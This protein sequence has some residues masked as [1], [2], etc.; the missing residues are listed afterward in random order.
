MC[1]EFD[2]PN[3]VRRYN[4]PCFI[5]EDCETLK[6]SQSVTVLISFVSITE[7]LGQCIGPVLNDV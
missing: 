7:V 4:T 2:E 6:N 3:I 1:K 5:W